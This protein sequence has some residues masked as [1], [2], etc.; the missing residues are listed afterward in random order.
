MYTCAQ[1]YTNLGT[2]TS[3]HHCCFGKG[4]VCDRILLLRTGCFVLQETLNHLFD[5]FRGHK[6]WI[7]TYL[8]IN[9]TEKPIVCVFGNKSDLLED[10]QVRILSTA[11]PSNLAHLTRVYSTAGYC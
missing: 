6:S 1:T 5:N 4:V 2:S 7:D 11:H 10:R 9:D 8:E 3:S